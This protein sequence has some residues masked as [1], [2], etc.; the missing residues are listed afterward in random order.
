MSHRMLYRLPAVGSFHSDGTT[1]PDGVTFAYLVAP[2][3][4]VED[5][6]HEGW[7]LTMPE[8]AAAHEDEKLRLA[9]EAAAKE[10][11]DDAGSDAQPTREE[12]EAQATKMGLKFDGRTTDKKLRAAIDA[13]FEKAGK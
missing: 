1:A 3:A 6:L 10:A 8:A 5:Y 7:H 11:D 4:A 12:L 13:E 9:E 2:D